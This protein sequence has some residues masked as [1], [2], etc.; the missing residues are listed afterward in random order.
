V[1]D[2]VE[3]AL[4]ARRP[5]EESSLV[6]HSDRGVQ[7]VSIRYI[8]RLAEAGIAPSVGSFGDSDDNAL[9]ESVIGLFKAEVVRRLGPWRN[10][11]AVAFATVALGLLLKAAAALS[12]LLRCCSQGIDWFNQR[13]LLKPSGRIPPWVLR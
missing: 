1:L 11:D 6:H 3:Q 7:D 8:E 5:T 2:A 13:R 10:I 4:H 9:A 12:G